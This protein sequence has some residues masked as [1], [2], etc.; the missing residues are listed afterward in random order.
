MLVLI[1]SKNKQNNLRRVKTVLRGCLRFIKIKQCLNY[2]NK[3]QTFY[4]KNKKAQRINKL[5]YVLK[6]V[7][8]SRSVVNNVNEMIFNG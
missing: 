4:M 5:L 1:C 3:T 8:M 2:L 6:Q 7:L